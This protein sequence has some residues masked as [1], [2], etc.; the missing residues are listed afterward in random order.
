[1]P[2]MILFILDFQVLRQIYVQLCAEYSY[3]ILKVIDIPKDLDSAHVVFAV[4]TMY[5][6]FVW[7]GG[8]LAFIGESYLAERLRSKNLGKD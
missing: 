4:L 7:C 5:W 3:V 2:R 6:G 1:M 8:G